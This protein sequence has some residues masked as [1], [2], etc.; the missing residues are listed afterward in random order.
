MSK[1]FDLY[2]DNFIVR[3][4]PSVSI[5]SNK[6]QPI[7]KNVEKEDGEM[8]QDTIRL[9]KRLWG[10]ER[11]PCSMSTS[12]L[13]SIRYHYAQV[14]KQQ[15]LNMNHGEFMLAIRHVKSNV[16]MVQ[17]NGKTH[18]GILYKLPTVIESMKREDPKDKACRVVNMGRVTRMMCVG[19]VPD[20]KIEQN[21]LTPSLVSYDKL[22][23]SQEERLK[24]EGIKPRELERAREMLN[25]TVK[26]L[27]D[28]HSFVGEKHVTFNY[29]EEIVTE[30]FME[31]MNENI[32]IS[33]L[34]TKF[35]ESTMKM[36]QIATTDQ[37]EIEEKKRR[38]AWKH[39][40]EKIEVTEEEK[41][42]VRG[43][44]DDILADFWVPKKK[45][46]DLAPNYEMPKL[47]VSKRQ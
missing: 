12:E 9:F 45:K 2:K 25:D 32:T 8:D 23:P 41:K 16:Y 7:S 38:E 33:R 43:N 26:K 24:A 1:P 20:S 18:Q 39:A 21:G 6:S 17:V 40:F 22:F 4:G 44:T 35:I 27:V 10:N 29:D 19:L 13:E 42:V 3:F 14:M 28:A 47:F 31:K 15:A 36:H 37:R 34:D 11:P 30:P 5:K 46:S